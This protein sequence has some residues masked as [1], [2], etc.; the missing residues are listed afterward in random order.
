MADCYITSIGCNFRGLHVFFHVDLRRRAA[1]QKRKGSTQENGG[2]VHHE[3]LA[4]GIRHRKPQQHPNS[5]P[6]T[7]FFVNF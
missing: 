6:G 7:C 1:R 3:V 2:T 4:D 5:G